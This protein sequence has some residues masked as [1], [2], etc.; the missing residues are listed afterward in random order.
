MSEIGRGLG[1]F[2]GEFKKG[3]EGIDEEETEKPKKKAKDDKLA[4]LGRGLGKAT[5]EFKKSKEE[6]ENEI[7]KFKSDKN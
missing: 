5:S 7:K 4:E 2:I 6:V 3:Q 1:R